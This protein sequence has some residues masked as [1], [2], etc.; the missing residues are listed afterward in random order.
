VVSEG[1][2]CRKLEGE[3][4]KRAG[5]KLLVKS[6]GT[7]ALTYQSGSRTNYDFGKERVR[8]RAW[9]RRVHPSEELVGPGAEGTGTGK[10]ERKKKQRESLGVKGCKSRTEEVLS[11]GPCGRETYVTGKEQGQ[12][13][14]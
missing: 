1:L 9:V 10:T 3:A 12:A 14:H 11:Y 13:C 4:G 7:R 2:E 6:P 8:N 5:L